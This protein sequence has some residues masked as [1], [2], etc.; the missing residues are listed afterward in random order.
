MSGNIRSGS[1][2]SQST[3]TPTATPTAT[4]TPTPEEGT[5]QPEPTQGK[6]YSSP[7]EMTIDTSKQY[8]AVIETDKGNISL[9]LFAADAPQTVNNFVFLARDG[10]YDGLTFYRVVP[11][12]VAQGGDPT[13]TASLQTTCT[14][15][16]GPGYTLPSET[17][18]RKHVEGS[19]AMAEDRDTFA[20]NGSQFFIALQ[21]LPQLDELEGHNTVF[22]Q[23]ADEDS[24]AVVLSLT[25]RDPNDPNA[26]PGDQI[27]S[28]TIEESDQTPTP[29][30]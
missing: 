20:I 7:P 19:M 13:C 26:P 1:N 15:E 8:F 30:E 18:E 24:M 22:A 27:L 21:D 5:P 11:D 16:G 10:F 3:A 25:P 29:T 4:T 2:N 12:F 28:V 14:G 9:E 23:V 6:T 17:N